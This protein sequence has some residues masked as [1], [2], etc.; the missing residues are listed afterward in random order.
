MLDESWASSAEVQQLLAYMLY[1][2][3]ADHSVGVRGVIPDGVVRS[4]HVIGLLRTLEKFNASLPKWNRSVHK[5]KGVVY[6]VWLYHFLGGQSA[7]LRFAPAAAAAPQEKEWSGKL[8]ERALNWRVDYDKETERLR[9][10][11]S[12]AH[13]SRSW[14]DVQQ[15]HRC[16]PIDLNILRVATPEDTARVPKKARTAAAPPDPPLTEPTAIEIDR[17]ATCCTALAMG[18]HRRLGIESKVRLLVGEH[19]VL[20]CI[21]KHAGIRTSAWLAKPPPKEVHQLRRSVF[22][23]HA[24]AFNLQAE[25]DSLRVQTHTLLQRNRETER[26][27]ESARC[28]SE[29]G[30][31]DCERQRALQEEY[32]EVCLFHVWLPFHSLA[33]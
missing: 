26:H 24:M 22:L 5:G 17:R 4:A 14:G 31:A 25:V 21:A 2:P 9:K 20:R 1:M 33:K 13:D 30:L 29:Q 8:R 18:T 6:H 12:R 15:A 10:E 23:E 11:H 28:R 27:A 19:D 7:N 3:G 32:V 16:A